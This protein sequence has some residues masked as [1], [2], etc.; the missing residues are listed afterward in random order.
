MPTWQS[1]EMVAPILDSL[2]SGTRRELP[3]NLPNTG[4]VAD[5]P[6]DAIVE[7]YCLVDGG[8]YLEADS[9]ESR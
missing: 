7:G 1:G 6:Q 8:L 2:I 5:A 9:R 3:L 4:H